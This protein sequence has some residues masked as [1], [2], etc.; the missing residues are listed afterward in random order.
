[1]ASEQ[2]LTIGLKVN[3]Q[4]P[5]WHES[6][7]KVLKQIKGATYTIDAEEGMAL[8]SGRANSNTILKKLKKS[9]SDVAWIKTGKPNT[10]CS[11]GYFE[12]D[13]YLQ[14]PYQPGYHH[15]SNYYEP[16]VPNPPHFEP[17]SYWSTRYY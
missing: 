12:G 14:Y 11:N 17:H 3:T 10:Y 4:S 8:V 16:Y 2:Y 7:T 1:M 6:L 9:G 13:S 15:Y 5:G